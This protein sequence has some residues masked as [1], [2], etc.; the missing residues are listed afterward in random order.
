MANKGQRINKLPRS[1]FLTIA[2]WIRARQADNPPFLTSTEAVAAVQREL[3]FTVSGAT[4][5]SIAKTCGVDLSRLLRHPGVGDGNSQRSPKAKA[6]GDEKHQ[7]IVVRLDALAHANR[8]RS[9]ELAEKIDLIGGLLRNFCGA[10]GVK[11]DA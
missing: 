5:R 10:F 6:D 4:F 3:G 1:A 8:I 9:D 7:E 2:D 11:A